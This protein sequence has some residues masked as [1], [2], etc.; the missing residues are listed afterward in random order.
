MGDD[1]YH[2]GA[3]MLGAN[4]GFYSSF[5]PRPGGPTPP[6]PALRFDPGTPDMYDFFLRMPP[7]ARANELL[8]RRRGGLLAG[9]RR[10]HDVRRVLEEAIALEVHGQRHVRGPERR[11]LVRCRGPRGTAARLSL[12]RAEEPRHGERAGDGAVVARRLGTRAR[13]QARQPVLLGEDRRVL[14]RADPVPVLREIPEG[15]DLR[16]CRRPTC[17]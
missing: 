16:I 17:S 2:N 15:Q 8:V 3:F 7:L 14:P 5:V 9:D 4:F 10:S 12:G 1:V 13:R 11:R 6:K